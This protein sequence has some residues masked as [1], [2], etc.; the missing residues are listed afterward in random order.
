MK[1]A[2]HIMDIKIS[3]VCKEKQ[4]KLALLERFK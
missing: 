4:A 2:Q 3:E 1:K